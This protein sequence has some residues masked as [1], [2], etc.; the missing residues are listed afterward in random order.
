MQE[1]PVIFQ[2]RHC[3]ACGLRL[4]PI[5]NPF[6][7]N[8]L[9]VY[10]IR[11]QVVIPWSPQVVLKTGPCVS[12]FYICLLQGARISGQSKSVC[13]LYIVRLY[14]IEYIQLCMLRHNPTIGSFL[15]LS[16]CKFGKLLA[17]LSL[18]N[19]DI[20]NGWSLTPCVQSQSHPLPLISLMHT[21][22]L[23]KCILKLTQ[24]F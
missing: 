7:L 14:H 17:P 15:L 19:A 10:S 13:L 1:A 23:D 24:L 21:I 8:I 2:L 20:L 16:I 12:S 3:F 11:L 4:S 6:I 5:V 9:F 22:Y 18:K